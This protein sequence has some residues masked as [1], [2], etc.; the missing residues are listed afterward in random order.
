MEITRTQKEFVRI[1]NK[2][3]GDYYDLYVQR[4]RLMLAD[5]FENFRNVCL[6]I[7]DSNPAKFLSDR[8]K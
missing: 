2:K 7:Y 4:D 6:K 8:Q 5:V 1:L 3:K